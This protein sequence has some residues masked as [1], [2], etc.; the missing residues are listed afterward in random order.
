MT[1]FSI[2][3]EDT[4][5]TRKFIEVT[6]NKLKAKHLV[7]NPFKGKFVMTPIKDKKLWIIVIMTPVYPRFYF[8]G[9][10]LLASILAY[11]GLSA[12]K[13]LLIPSAIMAGTIVLWSRYFYIPMLK[14][15]LRKIGYKGVIKHIDVEDTIYKI[16]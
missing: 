3:I 8:I 16:I 5:L 11:R 10:I 15:G 2:E 9:V 6:N 4:L 1:I 7:L 14:Y 13:W 12:P